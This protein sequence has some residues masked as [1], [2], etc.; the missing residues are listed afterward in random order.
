MNGS[1]TKMTLRDVSEIVVGSCVLGFPV[2]VT[3][4]VWDL[5]SA[6]PWSSMVPIVLWSIVFLGAFVHY[7]HHRGGI[8]GQ[9]LEF[10][11]RVLL[12]YAITVAC[13]AVILA[14]VDKLDLFVDPSVALKRTLLVAFPA[15]FA[16]TV[17]DSIG[18]QDR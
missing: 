1:D 10:I 2:A 6:L 4:E 11:G 8:R 3:G 18:T 13:C 7:L 16:A 12:S 5:S 17:V 9:R 14:L 15:C